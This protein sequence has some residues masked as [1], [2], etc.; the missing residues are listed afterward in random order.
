MR[1]AG[2]LVF[3][4]IL[5]LLDL[6]LGAALVVVAVLALSLVSVVSPAAGAM[7]DAGVARVTAPIGRLVATILL[8]VVYFLVI[9]PV[10]FFLRLFGRDLLSS[11]GAGPESTWVTKPPVPDPAIVRR[12]FTIE[13]GVSV[14]ERRGRVATAASFLV[15]TVGALMLL[16]A[17][18]LVIGTAYVSARRVL[19]SDTDVRAFSAGLVDEEWAVDY[20]GEFD[21]LNSA[22]E[23]LLGMVRQDYQGNYVN[24]SDRTRTTYVAEGVG[25]D[26]TSVY[27]FGGSTTWGTGQRDLYTI[28]SYVARL[29][30]EDGVPVVVSNYGQSGWVI[31]QELSLLQQ[32]LT[33]GNIPD[34]VVFYNGYNEVGQQ[35]QELTVDPSYPRADQVKERVDAASLGSSIADL[36]G[37]Y[38]EYSMM[39]RLA[40]IFRSNGSGPEPT[41]ELAQ[42]RARNAVEVHDRAV[43]V[44]ERLA[45]SYGFEVVFIWQPSAFTTEGGD[46]ARFVRLD[47][48]GIG[49]AHLGTTKLVGPPVIDLT[50]S[51]DGV[52]GAVF[53]DD[54]HTNELGAEIVARAIY[55][56]LRL[57]R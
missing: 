52:K 17:V 6:R 25:D 19:D 9:T 16:V 46:A 39:A 20:F 30:E 29:A 5:W 10:S 23:P 54:G 57:K 48:D 32:L 38:A 41:P 1:M 8:A 14:N 56:H 50:D 45:E 49:A 36:A 28:P 26:A 55:P 44:I 35:V 13:P 34:V 11:P 15:V 51:L 33:E 3:A 53:I 40:G 7:I 12:Q 21:E 37:H 31:W 42:A 22:W 27:F 43:D 47:R 2:G 4:A 18:D 24:I